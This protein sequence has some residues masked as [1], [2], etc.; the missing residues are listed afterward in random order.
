MKTEILA[1]LKEAEGF[2]SGQALCDRLGVSRT[3]VWKVIKQL[4]EEG[5]R[6]EAVRNKGYRLM[7]VADV[8]TEAEL[9]TRMDSKWM[10]KKLVY[11]NETDSTNIQA[12]KLAE[13]GAPSGTLVVAESQNAGKGR[14][15]RSWSSPPGSSI[16]MSVL[17]RPDISPQC[18]SAV[19][20]LAGMATARGIREK[21]GL[22]VQIKWPNDLVIDGR[23]IC[24]I[25]TEMSAEMEQIHYIVTGIGINVNQQEFPEEISRTATSLYLTSGKAFRRSE[26]IACTIHWFERYYEKF[27]SACDL[28]ALK[29]EYESMLANMDRE[30]AVL[31]PAGEYRGICRGIDKDGEL[32]VECRDGSIRRV[33][34]GEVS[35]RGIYGYV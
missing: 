22:P 23:K 15:G 12:R 31:D 6:I 35:V 19:T 20:L 9:A 17:L 7:E 24:G 21:T 4:E 29:E 14:R 3:A 16:Y 26:I 32:L 34:S 1:I 18:A 11:L 30:V 27:A 28:S 33:L 10:G 8:M 25:L 13:A 5:C 2:V